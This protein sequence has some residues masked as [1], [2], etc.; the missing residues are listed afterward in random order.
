MEDK[1]QPLSAYALERRA[2]ELWSVFYV[3]GRYGRERLCN[4]EVLYRAM[5]LVLN[6]MH[7]ELGP[8]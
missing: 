1:V 8:E 3:S 6:L 2:E 4:R 7:S 5:N